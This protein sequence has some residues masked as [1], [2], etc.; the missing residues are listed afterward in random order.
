MG[1]IP[2]AISTVWWLVIIWHFETLTCTLH[3]DAKKGKRITDVQ[4]CVHKMYKMFI[5]G[6]KK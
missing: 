3:N 6:W 4:D 2:T 5:T 1:R